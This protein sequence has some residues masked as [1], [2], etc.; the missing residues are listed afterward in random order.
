MVSFLAHPVVVL[1]RSSERP[2][3][4]FNGYRQLAA[5]SVTDG[6]GLLHSANS[7]GP[8]QANRKWRRHVRGEPTTATSYASW[9]LPTSCGR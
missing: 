5:K 9:T 3:V 2:T 8:L 6:C 7:L 4:G 1:R